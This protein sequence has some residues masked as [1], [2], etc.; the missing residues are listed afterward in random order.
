M[1]MNLPDIIRTT[2]ANKY[3][4]AGI[5]VSIGGA[6]VHAV[7]ENKNAQILTPSPVVIGGSLLLATEFGRETRRVFKR[8]EDAIIHN[9]EI[10]ITYQKIQ[11]TQYCTRAGMRAAAKKHGLEDQLIEEVRKEPFLRPDWLDTNE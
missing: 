8:T 6:Y 1:R 3:F 7:Q 11:S 2:Y 9:N 5:L 4:L 10:P